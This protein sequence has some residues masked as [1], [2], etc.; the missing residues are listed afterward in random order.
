MTTRGA[1]GKIHTVEI[2]EQTTQFLVQINCKENKQVD[3]FR[4]NI[5]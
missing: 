1:V 3:K 4:H 5:T 2:I